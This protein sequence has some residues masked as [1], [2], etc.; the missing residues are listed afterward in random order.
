MF[1]PFLQDIYEATEFHPVALSGVDADSNDKF[2][3]CAIK[4]SI[5]E[6]SATVRSRYICMLLNLRVVSRLVQWR[7]S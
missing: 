6:M 1:I 3:V 2:L 7:N 4:F 5:G